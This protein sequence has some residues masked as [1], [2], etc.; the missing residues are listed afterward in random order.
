MGNEHDENDYKDGHYKYSNEDHLDDQRITDDEK[1]LTK[2]D[3]IL[4][5]VTLVVFIISW[6]ISY[7]IIGYPH[8]FD[9]VKCFFLA[10]V[11][12]IGIMM[13]IKFF[14]SMFED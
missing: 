2:K 6:N 8:G 4:G 11:I 12:T 1:P 13:A 10:I 9:Y 3:K 7:D 14:I 5:F